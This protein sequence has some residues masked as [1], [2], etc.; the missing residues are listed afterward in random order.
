MNRTFVPNLL[1]LRVNSKFQKNRRITTRFQKSVDKNRRELHELAKRIY[2]KL[3]RRT[4]QVPRGDGGLESL[5]RRAK[6]RREIIESVDAN[7]PFV[8]P[9]KQ[10]GDSGTRAKLRLD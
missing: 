4:F 8:Y 5:L 1:A 7:T 6:R 2:V 9:A 10:R 3:S